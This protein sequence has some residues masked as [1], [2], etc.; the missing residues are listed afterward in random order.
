GT[1][2]IRYN[3]DLDDIQ[4]FGDEIDYLLRET[5][6][7][8]PIASL[9]REQILYTYSGVRPLPFAGA[10]DAQSITRRHFIHAHPKLRGLFSIVGGKL[11][12]YRSLAQQTVD[13]VL[14]ALPYPKRGRSA[15][16]FECATNRDP[17]PGAATADFD[18]SC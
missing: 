5:N 6:R 14:K 16:S 9:T 1:T 2:D 17:L 18:N 4:I 3:G 11:T 15:R 8:I 13:L 7:V 12:T 10:K